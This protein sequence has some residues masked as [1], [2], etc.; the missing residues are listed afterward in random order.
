MA[1]NLVETTIGSK[2][3]LVTGFA[4]KSKEFQ[5]KGIP[6][7]KIKNVKAGYFS[8]HE[9]SYLPE[10]YL[11]LRAEKLAFPHDLLISMTGNRYDGSPETWVGKVALFDDSDPHFI[12]QRVGA[13]RVNNK[14]AID[15]IYASYLLSSWQFQQ[16]F[17]SIATSSG[18]QANISP[19][20]ILETKFMAPQ[21]IGEQRAIARV[22]RAYDD[23]IELNRQ[24]NQT[25]ESMAQTLFKSWFVGF[26]PVIDNALAAGNE[27]PEPF[28]QRAAARQAL[29]EKTG[30]GDC[31]LPALPDNI[32]Q[33]FPSSLQFSEE[34]GWIPEAWE[35]CKLGELTELAYGKAL[36]AKVRTPGSIPVYGS[37]GITGF[38]NQHLVEGP[39]IIVGRKGTV[40]SVYWSDQNFFPIDTVFYAK[41]TTSISM[42]WL[43]RILIAIDIA[44][45]GADSAVPGVNRNAIY[46]RAICKPDAAVFVEFDRIIANY[47]NRISLADSQSKTLSDLRD[48]LLPR[49]L[50]GELRIPEAEKLVTKA[51]L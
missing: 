35:A 1:S 24:I 8:N 26:D 14:N 20:Q 21:D 17:I 40:G 25:F 43:Y 22:L 23:K 50:S 27:I 9:F 48:T 3:D 47:S 4:F 32:R 15:P 34:L 28:A 11:S 42:R 30:A 10:E 36:S 38:H 16:W 44:S 51:G 45:L 33:L 13:L 6:V 31:S 7:I 18:G 41:T 46:A 37:G 39:G 29:R 12:N 49:L 19:S 2:F 5:D